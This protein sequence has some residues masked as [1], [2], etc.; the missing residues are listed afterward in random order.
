MSKPHRNGTTRR[1]TVAGRRERGLVLVSILPITALRPE[2]LNDAI[3]RPVSEDDPSILE[4]ARDIRVRGVLEALVV[5]SDLVIVSGHRRY[6]AARLAGLPEVPC[7]VLDL[8]STDPDF[9]ALLVAYNTQRVK[10]LDEMAREQLVK[11]DPHEARQALAEDRRA[12]ARTCPG[13]V[14]AIEGHMRRARITKAKRP[15]L[16]AIL[17]VLRDRR[18]FWPLTVRQI[19]YALLNDPPLVNASNPESRYRNDRSSYKALS[20]LGL[21]ARVKGLLPWEAIHDPTR[22]VTVWDCH[23]SPQ[24]FIARQVDDFLKGYWRDLLQSQPNHIEVVIEKATVENIVRDVA[25]GYCLPVTPERG[26]CSGSPRRDMAERFRRGGKEKLV[27]L[28]LGDFDPDGEAI[29]NAFGK[30]MRD[31]FGVPA[32][33]LEP[34]WVALNH[35]Q[36]LEMDLPPAL[37]TKKTSAN[38]KK[39]VAKYGAGSYELEAV[40]PLRLQALLREAVEGV[41]DTGA[42]RAEQERE[43]EDAAQLEGL[44]RAL[45]RSL[46]GAITNG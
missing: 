6:A 45:K 8:H 14:Y 35:A 16:E 7:K 34:R 27:L 33:R 25:M 12:R 13:G 4:L 17:E 24:P 9:A 22:Q 11:L 15:F 2:R 23:P 40:P 29:V 28:I 1:A 3:Y 19:H 10:T 18:E 37:E 41:L 21:N 36:V 20:A 38:Y 30:S 5:T 42:F 39:F 43:A 32:G 26:Q 31:D 44:R 46:P